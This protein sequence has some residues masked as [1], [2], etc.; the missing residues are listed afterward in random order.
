MNQSRIKSSPKL[1]FKLMYHYRTTAE[2]K[3]IGLSLPLIK[4]QCCGNCGHL[5][6]DF[7]GKSTCG[8]VH[9]PINLRVQKQAVCVNHKGGVL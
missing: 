8:H 6:S 3:A 1:A 9:A 2:R 4:A 7:R 5:D